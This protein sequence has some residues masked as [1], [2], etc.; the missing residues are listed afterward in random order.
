MAPGQ[1]RL[2]STETPDTAVPAVVDAEQSTEA[3]AQ[4]PQRAAR[5]R[6]FLV[7]AG[8]L[9]LA[10]ALV[11]LG[12]WWHYQ[13]T[14]VV[15]R[16]A[17]VRSH[18]S[19]LGIRGEGV[20]AQVFVSAGDHVRKGELLA[21][22]ENAHLIAQRAQVEAQLKTLEQRI[23]VD[24]AALG[25]ARENARVSLLRAESEYRQMQA[26]AEAA[27]IQAEDSRAFHAARQ[28]LQSDGAVSAE[29]IRDAAAKAAMSSS[30]AAAAAAA[31]AGSQSDL[32]AARLA[33]EEAALR[34][35]ELL[36]LKAQREELLAELQRIAA[37]IESTRVTAPADGA[38]VRRLAQ[39]GMAV[40]TGMPLLSIWLTEDTWVEAWIPEEQL[41]DLQPGSAVSVSFP[42][43]P[44]TDF[45][46]RL[47]RVGLAT[48]FEMPV[49]YLPQTRE[50][51][52]RPT[53][54]IGVQIRL[55]A[56]PELMR[57]GM[58]AVV[59]IRRGGA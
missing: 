51:R 27:R 10:G 38:V 16:N 49:D 30:L 37:D 43:L 29:I 17:L 57:P 59:D 36:V 41:G 4:R 34:E 25:I 3:P 1:A 31:M 28:A 53:P 48:D 35:G 13:S 14:H 50:T 11:T 18:L 26:E 9:C 56:A 12:V 6:L 39:P 20:I 32:E 22:L 5:R 47:E 24:E 54:Q 2:I 33:E 45:P 58:S 46:G 52:M 55:D 40:K 44:H 7:L 15:T 42:A 23:A 8:S 21:V 19:E